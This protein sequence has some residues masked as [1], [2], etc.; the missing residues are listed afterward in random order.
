MS[1][2]LQDD[3]IKK[4]ISNWPWPVFKDFIE[5]FCRIVQVVFV[6]KLYMELINDELGTTNSANYLVF[7]GT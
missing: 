1:A 7:T 5:L 2:I 4:N 6:K 3:I